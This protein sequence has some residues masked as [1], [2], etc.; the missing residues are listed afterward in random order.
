MKKLFENWRKFEE[1]ILN[2]REYDIPTMVR[3]QAQ[4]VMGAPDMDDQLDVTERKVALAMASLV[5][6]TGVLEYGEVKKSYESFQRTGSYADVGW[7]VWA[8]LGALPYLK[9]VKIPGRISNIIKLLDKTK[10]VEKIAR[11]AKDSNKAYYIRQMAKKRKEAEEGVQALRSGGTLPDI[12]K[13]STPGG[14]RPLR[15]TPLGTH[16][17]SRLDPNETRPMRKRPGTKGN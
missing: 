16:G 8:I 10:G 11:R 12:S 13:L 14:T 5:E 7:L 17:T 3:G 2:E 4:K 6:P 9:Y 15:Q 1:E